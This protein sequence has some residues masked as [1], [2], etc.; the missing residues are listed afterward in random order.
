MSSIPVRN[1]LSCKLPRKKE[2][3][4]ALFSLIW[5]KQK[6]DRPLWILKEVE[7]H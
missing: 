1:S 6:K 5:K 3:L 4:E 2:A 7:F